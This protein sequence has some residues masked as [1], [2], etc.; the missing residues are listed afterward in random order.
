MLSVWWGGGVARADVRHIGQ[1]HLSYAGVYFLWCL[2]GG[3]HCLFE[4]RHYQGG[5][6]CVFG[7]RLSR[8]EDIETIQGQG[9]L[10]MAG[11][12]QTGFRVI[13]FDIPQSATNGSEAD[14]DVCGIAHIKNHCGEE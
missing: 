12:G 9:I 8:N 2:R 1:V 11:A 10:G 3:G 7:W 13:N 6:A 4:L 5:K 14:N